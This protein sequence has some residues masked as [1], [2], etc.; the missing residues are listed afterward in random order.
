MARYG[1]LPGAVMPVAPA[2]S[3][4]QLSGRPVLYT[5]EQR[6]APART[7]SRAGSAELDELIAVSQN[8]LRVVAL[9]PEKWMP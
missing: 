3:S 8:T 5:A 2:R 4:G 6:G 7:V 9:A 1:A